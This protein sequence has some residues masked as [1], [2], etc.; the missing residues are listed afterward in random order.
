[1]LFVRL[2][3]IRHEIGMLERN[4]VQAKQAIDRFDRADQ[5]AG[6]RQE[7][8]GIKSQMTELQ[9]RVSEIE[10]VRKMRNA[11]DSIEAP[12]G[13]FILKLDAEWPNSPARLMVKDLTVK[14]VRGDTR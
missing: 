9:R 4:S 6:L 14:V 3:E 5:S 11:I 13:R 7:I 12:T 10:I 2:N 8:D 1:M